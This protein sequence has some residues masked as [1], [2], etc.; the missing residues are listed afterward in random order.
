MNLQNDKW[1]KTLDPEPPKNGEIDLWR[2]FLNRDRKSISF[3]FD[4][5]SYD[6]KHRANKYVFAKDREHYVA[7]RATLRKIIGRY[8]G[9]GPEKVRFSYNRFG[10][11]FMAAEDGG[12][13]FNV[14]HSRGVGLIAI[15]LNR[16]VGVDIEF[17]DHKFHVFSVANSAFSASEVLRLRSLPTSLQTEVFFTGWTRKEASLKAMG[18]G[19]SSFP[20][21]Q[22]VISAINGEKDVSFTT[23]AGDEFKDWSLTSLATDDRYKASLAVEGNIGTV[24][25]WQ[26]TENR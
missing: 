13:R 16:E 8:L 19:L 10:K 1:Q 5:L 26:L 25:Y 11:P 15:A 2:V 17:V 7:C 6:E 22:S 21:H 23:F 20:E 4:S 24:R 12:L 3:L 14:S 9:L 18:Y